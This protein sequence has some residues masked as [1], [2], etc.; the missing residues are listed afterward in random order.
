MLKINK[1]FRSVLISLDESL[2]GGDKIVWPSS[3]LTCCHD[4]GRS[5][6]SVVLRGDY[7]CDW[8]SEQVGQ[9]TW[10]IARAGRCR[11]SASLCSKETGDA[12]SAWSET[13]LE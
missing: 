9:T 3:F 8:W 2:V 5:C 13:F 7:Y 10:S 4:D 6:R 11:R 1:I 12:L